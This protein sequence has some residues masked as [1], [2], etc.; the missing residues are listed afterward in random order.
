VQLDTG[1]G[2]EKNRTSLKGSGSSESPGRKGAFHASERGRT[3]RERRESI[4]I[5]LD[6]QDPNGRG[7]W[8]CG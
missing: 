4:G 8:T 6:G 5:L 2:E 3:G 7:G 1:E